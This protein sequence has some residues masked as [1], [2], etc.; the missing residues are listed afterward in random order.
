[1]LTRRRL[2]AATGASIGL[3]LL[4]AGCQ[5]AWRGEG[6]DCDD[7]LLEE[8][9]GGLLQTPTDAS[10]AWLAEQLGAGRSAEEL[11]HVIASASLRLAPPATL[12]REL[13]AAARMAHSASVLVDNSEGDPRALGTLFRVL[14]SFDRA[15]TTG[16]A[17]LGALERTAL[18]SAE[19]AR[20]ALQE[21]LARFEPEAAQ[22]AIIALGRAEG[23]GSAFDALLAWGP[24]SQHLLGHAPLALAQLT[25]AWA[26]FGGGCG[27][28]ALRQLA[29]A[30]ALSA[31]G[32]KLAPFTTTKVRRRELDDELWEQGAALGLAPLEEAITD[33]V[34]GARSDDPDEAVTRAIRWLNE[35]ASAQAVYTAAALAG[36]ELI[37][38]STS[39]ELPAP[40]SAAQ[41]QG[42]GRRCVQ[43]VAA[44]RQLARRADD[45]E[46]RQQLALTAAAWLPAFRDDAGLAGAPAVS[47]LGLLPSVVVPTTDLIF[48]SIGE[49]PLLAARLTFALLTDGGGR[50][51]LLRDWTWRGVTLRGGD[52]EAQTFQAAVFEEAAV[53]PGAWGNRLLAAAIV[54]APG[55]HDERWSRMDEVE[56][57]LSL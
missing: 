31:P 51:A 3:G 8:L 23:A 2:L 19:A 26:R 16:G 24:R 14:D 17:P 32:A 46:L 29:F 50:G 34:T 6:V 28:I 12:D 43:T 4:P 57:L 20:E 40:V 36:V 21:A 9:T 54:A 22:L 45:V 47:V 48:E 11:L 42:A 41:A 38:R 13:P 52:E 53:A 33:L 10:F 49:D 56:Q 1:M 39:D 35:G 7:P 55:A 27:E 5:P 44:L 37:L 25:R 30:L 18:P 15:R